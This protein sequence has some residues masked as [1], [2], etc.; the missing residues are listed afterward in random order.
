[1]KEV[2]TSIETGHFIVQGNGIVLPKL[3]N[4]RIALKLKDIVFRDQQHFV[5]SAL[6]REQLQAVDFDWNIFSSETLDGR[7]NAEF[8]HWSVH[9]SEGFEGMGVDGHFRQLFRGEHTVDVAIDLLVF[10]R[11]YDLIT[12]WV[13][14]LQ[15]LGIVDIVGK[16]YIVSFPVQL[17]NRPDQSRFSLLFWSNGLLQ[18]REVVLPDN[19][20]SNKNDILSNEKSTGPL[21][22]VNI[23]LAK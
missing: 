21:D 18:H 20:Q 9:Q 15:R 3:R 16:D 12:C 13:V 11:F 19:V 2:D 22:D 23:C 7:R 5:Y 1:M 8:G 17:L 4:I 6:F 14:Y 10:D